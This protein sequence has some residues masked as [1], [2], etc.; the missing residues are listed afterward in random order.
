MRVN[1]SQ[2]IDTSFFQ[3]HEHLKDDMKL[4]PNTGITD[5]K[6]TL[7]FDGL[8]PENLFHPIRIQEYTKSIHFQPILGETGFV[9]F[10]PIFTL[11]AFLESQNYKQSLR[12]S[13]QTDND[14]ILVT[15]PIAMVFP[16]SRREKRPSCCIVSKVSMQTG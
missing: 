5:G 15:L 2:V 1:C 3:T 8:L 16:S 12:D 10:N 9:M 6:S 14:I 13:E 11:M 7:I 4:V